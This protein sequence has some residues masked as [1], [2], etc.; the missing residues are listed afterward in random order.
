M[1]ET[2]VTVLLIPIGTESQKNASSMEMKDYA[3]LSAAG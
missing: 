2:Y 1:L 3:P